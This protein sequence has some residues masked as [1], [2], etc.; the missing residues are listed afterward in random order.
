M[1]AKLTF[2]CWNSTDEIVNEM[3]KSGMETDTAGFMQLWATFHKK[4]LSVLDSIVG[5]S[6]TP[7]ILWSSQLTSPENIVNFL[8]NER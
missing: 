5:D 6:K 4:S 1:C 3:K 2:Q 7:V 8:S